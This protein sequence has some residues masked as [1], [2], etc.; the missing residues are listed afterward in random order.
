MLSA[1]CL[2]YGSSPA[3]RQLESGLQIRVQSVDGDVVTDRTNGLQ[4][5]RDVKLR[6]RDGGAVVHGLTGREP[7]TQVDH[8]KHAEILRRRPP[9]APN[10]LS[11][12]WAGS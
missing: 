7:A 3:D 5:R 1:L 11:G 12:P 4:S 8:R 6:P 10:Y 9:T 2:A